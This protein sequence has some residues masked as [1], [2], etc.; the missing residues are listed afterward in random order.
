MHLLVIN[1]NTTAAV[2]S[3]LAQRA[4]ELAPAGGRVSA[5]TA[6]FGA[7]YISDELSVA[8]AGHAFLDALAE[9]A[10][11]SADPPDAVLLGC[12]GD[13]GLLAARQ[14]SGVPVVGMAESAM[15][16]AA[17]AGRFGIVTGGPAWAPMLRRLAMALGLSDAL[18]AI[19]AV[20][21][22]GA[23]LAADRDAARALLTDACRRCT[24]AGAQSIVVGG[25]ALGGLAASM[26]PQVDV[27]L[28]DGVE[29]A[30]RAAW[31]ATAEPRHGD[32]WPDWWR[33]R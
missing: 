19:D 32:A 27:P 8:V 12:F 31:A 20:Q 13:P 15:R 30:M 23:E 26:Q 21:R 5:R 24:A 3:A 7:P 28:L 18:V 9:A 22:T 17:A 4:R 1:P 10:A 11:D 33:R 2:T 29:V 16:A 25:A 6:R 14:A